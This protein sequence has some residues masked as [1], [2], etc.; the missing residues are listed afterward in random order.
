MKKDVVKNKKESALKGHWLWGVL[1]FGILLLID[2]LTKVMAEVYFE[3]QGHDD[4]VVIPGVIELTCVYNPGAA[5]SIG[6]DANPVVKLGVVIATAL[7]M[8]GASVVY[9]KMDKRRT[10]VRWCLVLIVAGGVGNLIDRV[11]YRMW[12]VDGGGVRDMV[13]L[14]FSTLLEQWFNLAP[15]NFLYFGVCNFADFFIV[16]GAVALMLGLLFFDTDAF[17]PVGKYKELAKEAAAKEEAKL[18]A[19][20]A[21]QEGR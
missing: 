11:L 13:A 10:F 12:A 19:K 14:D 2:L 16:G 15:T 1:V 7:I 21:Q 17:F 6:A 18:A 5:F 3:I 4:I 8:V 20:K 9:F